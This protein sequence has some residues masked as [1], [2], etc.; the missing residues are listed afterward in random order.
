MKKLVYL[1]KGEKAYLIED[2]SSYTI[3]VIISQEKYK[4]LEKSL[5]FLKHLRKND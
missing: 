5:L 1:L 4:E 2:E 3:Y